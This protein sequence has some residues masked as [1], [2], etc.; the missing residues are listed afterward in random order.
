MKHWLTRDINKLG[1]V[2]AYCLSSKVIQ[3][4]VFSEKIMTAVFWDHSGVLIVGFLFLGDAITAKCYCGTLERLV[5]ATGP[6][7]PGFLRRGVVILPGNARP[8]TAN[9][10]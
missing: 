9:D 5:Q 3:S 7:M 10:T 8:L 2:N 6:K 4:S 1:R